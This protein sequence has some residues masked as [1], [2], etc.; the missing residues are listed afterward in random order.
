MISALHNRDPNSRTARNFTCFSK[1]SGKSRV[2]F[3]RLFSRFPSMQSRKGKG[4]SSY[5]QMDFLPGA[6]LPHPGSQAKTRCVEQVTA[7]TLF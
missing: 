5:S 1:A 4:T 2:V 7:V 6:V 3:M